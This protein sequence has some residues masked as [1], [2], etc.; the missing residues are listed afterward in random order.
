[1]VL[2]E[3][4]IEMNNLKKKTNQLMLLMDNAA[5]HDSTATDKV[6]SKLLGLL[7]KYRSHLIL[8]NKI[9]NNSEVIVGGSRLSLA[10][11]I[12]ILKTIASKMGIL[13]RLINKED[14]VL[15][16]LS[17]VD[18]YDALLEEYTTISKEIKA[19]EWGIEI[20]KESVG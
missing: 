5:T 4:L 15:D 6:T 2:A 14:S 10:N 16:A 12:I 8:I 18:Q 17:L 1:M 20:D 3:V 7:D 19:Q 13:N 9:N 11:A